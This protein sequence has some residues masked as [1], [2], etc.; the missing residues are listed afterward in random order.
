MIAPKDCQ[1]MAEIRAEIDGLDRQIIARLGQRFKYV[2]AAAAFKNNIQEVQA[3]DRF[4]T[5]LQQRRAWA[6]IEGLDADVIEKLYRDLV[7][8]FINAELQ[9][10]QTEPS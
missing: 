8:Y 7:T 1:N 10:W 4:N 9:H 3:Q 2:Q 5:M 6:E